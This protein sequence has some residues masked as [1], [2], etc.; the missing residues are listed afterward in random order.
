LAFLLPEQVLEILCFYGLPVFPAVF[1]LQVHLLWKLFS[2]FSL[3]PVLKY[4]LLFLPILLLPLPGQA[5]VKVSLLLPFFL[6]LFG[7]VPL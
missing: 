6:Q 2:F 1:L 3:Q 5:P 4:L 7:F